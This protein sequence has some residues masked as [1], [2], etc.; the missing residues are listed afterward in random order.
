MHESEREHKRFENHVRTENGRG[1]SET[2]GANLA[3]TTI[4]KPERVEEL[5]LARSRAYKANQ[6]EQ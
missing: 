5:T 4:G 3:S 6:F 1:E 2:G